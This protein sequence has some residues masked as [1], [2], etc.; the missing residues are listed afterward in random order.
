MRPHW[1]PRFNYGRNIPLL[2]TCDHHH[3]SN[4]LQPPR[5]LFNTI[6][7]LFP[8]P[9]FY[10]STHSRLYSRTCSADPFHER[11]PGPCMR[12][13]ASAYCEL[14]HW[15]CPSSPPETS[16]SNASSINW[17]HHL[18][19]KLV[20][21]LPKSTSIPCAYDHVNFPTCSMPS[22]QRSM[23][24]FSYHLLGLGILLTGAIVICTQ[25]GS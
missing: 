20:A 16:I 1:N 17:V 18:S 10:A 9:K 11:D 8:Y 12:Q 15:T 3:H 23:R 22:P 2:C 5:S 21:E 25:S 6:P 19:K 13:T 24:E 4:V 7:P 14:C